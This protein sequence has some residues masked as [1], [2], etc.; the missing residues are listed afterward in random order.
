MSG[1][2]PFIFFP[3]VSSRDTQF[4]ESGQHAKKIHM[5]ARTCTT[6]TIAKRHT[7]RS[8]VSVGAAF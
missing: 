7:L 5:Y 4:G 8:V 1:K 3:S 6:S 2:P